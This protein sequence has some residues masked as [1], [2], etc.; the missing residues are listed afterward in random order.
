[1]A[2]APGQRKRSAARRKSVEEFCT[3]S[4]LFDDVNLAGNK[5]FLDVSLSVAFLIEGEVNY[6]DV[7][8]RCVFVELPL[9]AIRSPP[10]T[11]WIF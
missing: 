1:M 6:A 3:P 11:H 2:A 7:H 5:A 8:V 9:L 10:R 4:T